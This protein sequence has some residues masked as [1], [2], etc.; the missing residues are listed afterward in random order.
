MDAPI[1]GS[2]FAFILVHLS[3]V[4]LPLPSPPSPSPHHIVLNPFPNIGLM[5]RTQVKRRPH[6]FTPSWFVPPTRTTTLR[7]R[8]PSIQFTP[9]RPIYFHHPLLLRR[10]S[11]GLEVIGVTTC[12]SH[13]T[14]LTRTTR[15]VFDFAKDQGHFKRFCW[16]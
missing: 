6:T 10:M 11:N 1:S 12:T 5:I 14:T 7:A 8:A 16:S 4:A 15:C 9:D 13:P 2:T 3:S